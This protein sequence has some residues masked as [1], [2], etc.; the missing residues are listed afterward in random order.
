M[1]A[2]AFSR[3]RL[4]LRGAGGGW[5]V[6]SRDLRSKDK[7]KVV[8]IVGG[9]GGPPR[10]KSCV[11]WSWASFNKH[12]WGGHGNSSTRRGRPSWRTALA[13]R[14]RFHRHAFSRL[15][16]LPRIALTGSQCSMLLDCSSLIALRYRHFQLS[17][18]LSN[19]FAYCM[20]SWMLTSLPR[21]RLLLP[22][23]LNNSL[24]PPRNATT[25][26]NWSIILPLSRH[27]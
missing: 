26:V 16:T 13:W 14:T 18:Y 11:K 2:A 23:I 19:L 1:A 12:G 22:Y 4:A 20:P 17:L 15:L 25:T 3:T 7:Y 9:L 6:R 27:L 24:L 8:R 10:V 5:L 21:G